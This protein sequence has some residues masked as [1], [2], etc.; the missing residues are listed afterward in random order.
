MNEPTPYSLSDKEEIEAIDVLKAL[1]DRNR[2]KADIRERDKFPN[3]DGILEIINEKQIPIGKVDIQIRKIRPTAIK[4]TCPSSLVYYSEKSTLPVLFI[5]VDT[6]NKKAFWKHIH[7]TIPEFKENQKTFTLKFNEINDGIFKDSGYIEK[8]IYI[9]KDYQKRISDYPQLKELINDKSP[10]NNLDKETNHYFQIFTDTVNS[11]FETDFIAI[12]E[13]LFK[14]VW[15]FGV[16]VQK[17][18][19]HTIYGLYK[20]LRGDNVPIICSLTDNARE[21]LEKQ[22]RLLQLSYK[23]DEYLKDPK[24]EGESFVCDRVKQIVTNC[25]LTVHGELLS[26]ETLFYFIGIY[27]PRHKRQEDTYTLNKIISMFDSYLDNI[28]I[29]YATEKEPCDVQFERFSSSSIISVSGHN[30]PLS[31]DYAEISSQEINEAIRYLNSNGVEILNRPYP[32]PSEGKGP[33]RT[34]NWIWSGYT[35]ASENNRIDKILSSSIM[36]YREFVTGNKLKLPESSYLNLDTPVVYIYHSADGNVYERP[37]L[38]IFFIHEP[39][40]LPKM[41]VY[42]NNEAGFFEGDPTSGDIIILGTR[43]RKYSY[44]GMTASFLFYE[45]PVQKMIYN[46]LYYDL[47]KH[48]ESLYHLSGNW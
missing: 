38:D 28:A 23:T 21:K 29:E 36:E 19:G 46:M 13:M 10:V 11:L 34:G 31:Y 18:G 30:P 24:S 6:A 45:R 15:K 33:I 14:D 16:A 17:D 43:Y 7:I 8:W 3:T 22:S 27:T 41:S 20:I 39:S 26:T 48:Y 25:K 42:V 44:R 1:L 32:K 35:E 40:N 12:K 9:V 4:A 37:S 5:G 2:I 47:N